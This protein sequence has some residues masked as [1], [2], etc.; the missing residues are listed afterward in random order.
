[1]YEILS[2]KVL[3]FETKRFILFIVIY[4]FRMERRNENV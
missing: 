4:A 1:M 2:V 3:C